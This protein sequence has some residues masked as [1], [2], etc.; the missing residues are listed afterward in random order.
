MLGDN[1]Y[2]KRDD[3]VHDFTMKMTVLGVMRTYHKALNLLTRMHPLCDEL[4]LSS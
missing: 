1:P 3:V 4:R 2:H